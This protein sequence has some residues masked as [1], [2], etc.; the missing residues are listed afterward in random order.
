[1]KQSAIGLT[2]IFALFGCQPQVQRNDN[3]PGSSTRGA[4]SDDVIDLGSESRRDRP[5]NDRPAPIEEVDSQTIPFDLPI[6]PLSDR[7]DDDFVPF[8]DESIEIQNDREGPIQFRQATT[9]RSQH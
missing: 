4:S 2:L 6:R 5:S 8:F 1:M 9:R 7:I 3:R